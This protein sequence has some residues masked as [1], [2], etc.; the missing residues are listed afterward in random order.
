M[1]KRIEQ[2]V[3][4]PD[5]IETQIDF[6][7]ANSYLILPDLLAPDEVAQLNEAIDRDRAENPFMWDRKPF[8]EM[9]DNSNLLLNEP[10]FEIVIH[11]PTVLTFLARLMRGPF[12][13]EQLTVSHRDGQMED[14][15]TNWHR[16]KDHWLEH[17]LH[18]DYPQII[19]Y[20]T[21]VDETTHCF[22]I[23]QEPAGGEILMDQE[24]QLDRG[25]VLDFYG[26]AGRFSH[27][28][29]LCSATWS[30]CPQNGKIRTRFSSILDMSIVLSSMKSR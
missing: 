28:L 20:L 14:K 27:P 23:S 5:N 15:G 3:A 12:C 13:F 8:A 24:A 2:D 7:K 1:T 21:D 26:R 9:E 22:S 11:R 29:Q 17:P 30:H 6:F 18:L 16:D 4:D 25:G 19:Y 10:I